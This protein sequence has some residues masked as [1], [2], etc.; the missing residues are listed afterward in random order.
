MENRACIRR[1]Q[2][3]ATDPREAVCEF[4]AAV[5]Q[6]EMALVIFFCS[7]EYDLEVLAGEMR[8]LFGFSS[9]GEQYRGMQVNQTFTGIAIGG[10]ATET[11]GA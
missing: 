6:P 4:H 11:E 1:A 2:S 5:A 8:R 9:Y 10:A 3:C 7:S